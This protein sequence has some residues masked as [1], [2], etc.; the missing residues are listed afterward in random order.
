MIFFSRVTS[1][2]C[3]EQSTKSLPCPLSKGYRHIRFF[4]RGVMTPA[5]MSVKQVSDSRWRSQM[6]VS[7][8][9]SLFSFL[10]KT[11]VQFLSCYFCIIVYLVESLYISTNLYTSLDILS[12][13]VSSYRFSDFQKHRYTYI[14]S[15]IQLYRYTVR[16]IKNYIT[17]FVPAWNNEEKREIVLHL[18]ARWELLM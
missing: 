4:L 9:F 11:H 18:L 17:R 6:C 5:L 10:S 12:Y 8:S 1:V 3:L 15:Y 13:I 14:F 16:K 2:H 7:L